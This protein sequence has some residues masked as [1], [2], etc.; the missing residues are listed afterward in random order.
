MGRGSKTRR[1]R[2]MK[3]LTVVTCVPHT[4]YLGELVTEHEKLFADYSDEKWIL[5]VFAGVKAAGHALIS[6]EITEK[7]SV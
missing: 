1:G 7:E 2:R 3:I 4:K 6:Y 5:S